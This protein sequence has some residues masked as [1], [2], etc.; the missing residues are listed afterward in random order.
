MQ[1]E[2]LMTVTIRVA[3]SLPIGPTGAG[4]RSIGIV[5]DGTFEGPRLRGS[6]VA[7]GADWVVID[8]EGWG[9]IDVRLA[10][11]TD[12]GANIYMRY[13]GVLEPDPAL[14]AALGGGPPTAFGDNYFVTQPRFECGA[15]AYRWLNRVVAIAEGRALTGGAE[16]RIYH[17]KPGE[18]S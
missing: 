2:Y 16:Y 18:A 17:C 10:L 11:V 13:T 6:V 3:G 5:G 15:P 8:D 9:A 14:T 7:P 4:L 12:D 1:I